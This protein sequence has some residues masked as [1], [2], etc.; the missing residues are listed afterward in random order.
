MKLGINQWAFPS[1]MPAIECI[2]IAREVGFEAF[3]VCVGESG[4]T[5]LDA[6]EKELT[7]I[8]SYAEKVGVALHS[9]GS[10]AGWSL[11]LTSTDP[12]N[13]EQAKTV[14]GR[15]LEVCGI[16]GVDTLLVVPGTVDTET[17][18]DVALENALEGIRDLVPLAEKHKVSI[19]IEN[20]WNR[21][22]LSPTEMRDFIDHCESEYVGAY[23]DVGNM[24]PYGFPEQWIRILGS[25]VH[26]IHMKDFRASA[27]TMAGFVMLMEG[28]VNWP[29]VISALR[30]IGYDRALTA[31]FGSYKYS[32]DTMLRHVLTSLQAIVAL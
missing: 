1:E 19:G 27:G 32:N 26:A 12:A 9:V 22:L 14:T 16:L 6:S 4:P 2:R 21:F 24:I 28:D 10:G 7:E 13:R 18:Y 17:P 11:K 8:R 20:V 25:R 30:E 5:R 3:E 29:S 23:V 31:E 15:T